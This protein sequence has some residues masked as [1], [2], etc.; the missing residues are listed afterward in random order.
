[1]AARTAKCLRRFAE[2]NEAGLRAL[3][4]V[5]PGFRAWSGYELRLAAAAG[6]PIEIED[7]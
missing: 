2:G 3:T 7:V 5:S 1:M 4:Y 6:I